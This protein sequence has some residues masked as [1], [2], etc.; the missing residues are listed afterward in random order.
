MCFCCVLVHVCRTGAYATAMPHM[1]NTS[2]F[3]FISLAVL[4][5][6]DRSVFVHLYPCLCVSVHVCTI[7]Y[8][9]YFWVFII[10]LNNMII[11]LLYTGRYFICTK[12]THTHTHTHART[13][14]LGIC[15]PQY[16]PNIKGMIVIC[17]CQC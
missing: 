15:M 5:P 14:I 17:M 3:V 8:V 11:V 12:G 9:I 2:S 16:C 13:C 10:L 4:S 6:V 1:H 7:V